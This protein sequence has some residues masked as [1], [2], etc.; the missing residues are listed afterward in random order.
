MAANKPWWQITRTARQ[1]FVMGTLWIVLGLVGL[2]VAHTPGFLAV[3][4][5]WLALG[6]GYLVAAVAL[7]R[8]ERSGSGPDS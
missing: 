8:R 5:T 2:L 6:G 3:S 1:G 4:A 7:R